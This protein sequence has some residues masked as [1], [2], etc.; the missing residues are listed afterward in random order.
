MNKSTESF[1]DLNPATSPLEGVAAR[2]R[3][4]RPSKLLLRAAVSGLLGLGAAACGE[5][6]G[7]G[8]DDPDEHDHNDACEPVD[9]MVACECPG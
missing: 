8:E 5:D 2:P 1:I 7:T 3:S 4:G 6:D 9:E